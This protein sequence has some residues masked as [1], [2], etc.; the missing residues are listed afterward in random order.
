MSGLWPVPSNYK[1]LAL[2]IA[3][4]LGLSFVMWLA[5]NQGGQLVQANEVEEIKKTLDVKIQT[6]HLTRLLDRVGSAEAQELLYHSGLPFT[7]Q[8]HLLVHV[9]GDY[10]YKKDGLAGLPKC[11]EYFLSACYHGFVINALSDY[12]IDGVADAMTECDK[13]GVAVAT[14]CSHAAG[15]GFLAWQD[16]NLVQALA[17]CDQAA[18]K[19][20]NFREFNCHDG[21]F[22][23]NFWGVHDGKPSDK[24]WLSDADIYYP[25]TDKRIAAKYLDGCWSNQATV[26]YQHFGGDLKK[27]AEAC[28]K[29]ASERHKNT[30]YNNFARQVHPL[31]EGDTGKAFALC[32]NAT[33]PEWQNFCL[34]ILVS[35]AWSVGDK[36]KMPFEIC[37]RIAAPEQPSCYSRLTN[38]FKFEA[39]D[40]RK[41]FENYC[42]KINNPSYREQCLKQP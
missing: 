27:T 8:T 2:K 24:R 41:I 25:C 5:L 32:Q 28:D 39:K 3:L 20:K 35:A 30:C 6:E 1:D 11:R 38:S 15:H 29:V 23:E 21:A 22:M 13:A 18:E 10:I 17:M 36:S 26:I 12:G 37:D 4:I 14:Q 31:T 42:R 33:G 7:G 34:K 19:S 40:D 16:Y 9:I